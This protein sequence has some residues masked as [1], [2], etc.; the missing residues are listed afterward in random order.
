MAVGLAGAAVDD[1]GAVLAFTVGVD[2]SI[3]G[4]RSA[5]KLRCDSGSASSQTRSASCRPTGRGKWTSSAL[6]DK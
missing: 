5:P 1:L 6:S 2:A 4:V 3:E